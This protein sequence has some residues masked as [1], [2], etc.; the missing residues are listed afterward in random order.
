MNDKGIMSET[1]YVFL[2]LEAFVVL[3]LSKYNQDILGLQQLQSLEHLRDCNFL[4]FS[5]ML[6]KVV[7]EIFNIC[8]F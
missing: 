4:T 8:S 3:A 6:C 5:V 7:N 1:T 2:Q